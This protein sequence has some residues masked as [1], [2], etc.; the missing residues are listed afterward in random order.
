[1]FS[2]SRSLLALAFSLTAGSAGAG[3]A[4]NRYDAKVA[5]SA[6]SA[7]Y[8]LRYADELDAATQVLR[9]DTQRAHDLTA[10]LPA[11]SQDVK[12][13]ADRD[14]LLRIIEQSDA[15]GRGQSYARVQA[16]E[17]ALR[18]F[19]EAE[20]G[21]L[22]ARA[23]S[24]AQK[25]VADAGCTQ[26]VELG[27]TMQHA[28][29]D[30]IDKQLERRTRAANE[31]QR[32]LEQHKAKLPP[33]ST[34]ALQRLSDEV[35]QASHLVHVALPADAEELSRLLHERSQ[36]EATLARLLDE[37]RTL[38]ADPHKPSEQKASQ[39]RVVQIEKSRS[40]LSGR[41]KTAEDAL[42]DSSEASRLA[43]NEYE[44]TIEAIKA[45]FRQPSSSPSPTAA[46]A[47]K[48]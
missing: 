19:W 22:A 12:P 11:H 17:R 42:R 21:P 44:N 27:G 16:E 3:C 8:A 40:A 18:A 30:G 23:S 6:D 43:Q 37:E 45:S 24:A 33:G 46:A 34:V 38:Q 32:T 10:S 35:A 39:E 41:A 36:V 5:S 47:V 7:G 15:A 20:R 29:R 31:G 13:G 2:S 26:T 4:G 9:A 25:E 1:M 48:G 14:V 28:L